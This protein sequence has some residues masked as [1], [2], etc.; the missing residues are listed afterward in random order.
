MKT[1]KAEELI[2]FA[3]SKYDALENIFGV[4]LFH[5]IP[6]LEIFSSVKSRNDWTAKSGEQEFKKFTGR[7]LSEKEIPAAIDAPFGAIE[8]L[9]SGYLD[10]ALY[11]GAFRKYFQALDCLESSA[12]NYSEIYSEKGIAHTGKYSST[13]IIFAK[14]Q[15]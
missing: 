6:S 12:V 3:F 15:V 13:K 7:I 8:L 9:Q 10:T 1:W 5:S 2:P 14:V 11:T 4:K